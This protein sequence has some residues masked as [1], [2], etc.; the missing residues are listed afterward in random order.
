MNTALI[1]VFSVSED[2]EELCAEFFLSYNSV[3]ANAGGD[4]NV[5]FAGGVTGARLEA[6]PR[7]LR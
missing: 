1:E 3:S 7:D 6:L 4:K 5:F 2:S